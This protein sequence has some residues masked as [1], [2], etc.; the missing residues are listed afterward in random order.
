[1]RYGVTGRRKRNVKRLGTLQTLRQTRNAYRGATGSAVVTAAEAGQSGSLVIEAKH[2]SKAYDGRAIVT[3]FSTRI[4]RGDRIGI[5]G[6]TAAA[7]PR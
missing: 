1:M 3:D 7:R 4:R 6:P 2:L 5:V